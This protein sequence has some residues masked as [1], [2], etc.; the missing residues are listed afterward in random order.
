MNPA[1]HSPD[2]YRSL[3]LI[4][5]SE[6]AESR[7]LGLAVTQIVSNFQVPSFQ[8][9]CTEEKWL[10]RASESQAERVMRIAQ[11]VFEALEHTPVSAYGINFNLHVEGDAPDVHRR[12]TSRIGTI[13]RLEEE[14]EFCSL[15]YAVLLDGRTLNA[16]I[17]PSRQQ[18]NRLFM[19]L[20]Y[21]YGVS[22]QQFQ[23]FDLG[24]LLQEAAERDRRDYPG[25]CSHLIGALSEGS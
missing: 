11:G 14:V 22:A 1:I 6:L 2:W 18:A 21:H 3:E 12:F 5:D 10:I 24:T 20:N 7:G 16:R 19:S 17:E 25:R 9:V 15:S 13:L 8:V 23:R 4:S